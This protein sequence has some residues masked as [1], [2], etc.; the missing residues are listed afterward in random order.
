M[1]VSKVVREYIIQK[2][3]EKYAARL[4][5]VGAE[6]E[7]TQKKIY[8]AMEAFKEKAEAELLA[9]VAEN[10]D[11]FNFEFRYSK[12]IALGSIADREAQDKIYEEERKIRAERDEKINNIIIEL[13]LGGNKETLERL[14][15]EL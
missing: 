6:Y 4:K 7:K 13:E 10:S 2:V 9:I 12:P 14:L 11:G 1:R 8:E 3:T 15:A 5:A